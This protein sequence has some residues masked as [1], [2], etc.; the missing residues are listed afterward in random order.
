MTKLLDTQ[1]RTYVRQGRWLLQY[2]TQHADDISANL[3]ASTPTPVT[4]YA[5]IP[6][7]PYA[8]IPDA[9][10][11]PIHFDPFSYGDTQSRNV[12]EPVEAP[13]NV[14]E[15][16]AEPQ[17]MVQHVVAPVEPQEPNTCRNSPMD[18]ALER[19]TTIVKVCF[20][21]GNGLVW[22]ENDL[23]LW[24]PVDPSGWLAK[25]RDEWSSRIHS[26]WIDEFVNALELWIVSH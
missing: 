24:D 23:A 8:P 21:T 20:K 9:P 22:L 13:R 12:V 16:V 10:S 2:I 4:P 11:A 17:D 7:A 15:P 1:G 26:G 19:L 18:E 5:P 25:M 6:D 3:D 14:V